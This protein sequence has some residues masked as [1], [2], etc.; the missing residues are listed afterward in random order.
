M[1][2]NY[3]FY[4]PHDRVQND[5]SVVHPITGEISYPPSKT[6]QALLA[7]CDINRIIKLYSVTG[8]VHH[9]SARAALGAYMDLP[10][11]LDYQ[12]ALNTVLEGEKAFNSLPAKVRDR[13]ENDPAD[14]LQ[15]LSDPKNK[16]EAIELGLV[17][18]PPPAAP[19]P[20]VSTPTQEPGA[21]QRPA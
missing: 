15:F 11:N 4:R 12:A 9:V 21:G 13:F 10:D 7:E 2:K 8:Q 19:T 18:P 17:I 20:P 5:G 6:K 1:N 14:F 16:A 3:S